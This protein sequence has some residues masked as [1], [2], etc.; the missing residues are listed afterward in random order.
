MAYVSF[1]G[2]VERFRGQIYGSRK[3]RLRMRLVD[4]LYRKVLPLDQLENWKVLD[5]GGGLGQ[6]SH[7]F[8]EQGVTS[9]DYLDVSEQMVTAA[10]ESLQ[11]Y[12]EAGQL[13][14]SVGSVTDLS[15]WP[16]D[17]DFVNVHAVLEWLEKPETVVPILCDRVRPGGYLGLM[18]YNRHML[19]MRHMMRGTL[20]RAMSGNMAGDKR[21]LTPISPMDPQAVAK[22]LQACGMTILCQAG[23][24]SFSDLTEKAVLE[25][26]TEEAVFDAEQALCEQRPYCDLGRYTLFIARKS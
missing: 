9:V 7:W 3:G 26:Y 1:D 8:L 21:G 20:K 18:V 23:I 5:A 11:E 14:A 13:N 15:E 22:D 19:M 17:Y 16:S 2:L 12:Y 6:M 10:T 25:W 24:R 4:A